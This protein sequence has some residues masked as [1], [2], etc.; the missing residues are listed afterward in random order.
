ML[1]KIED[2]DVGIALWEAGLLLNSEGAEWYEVALHHTAGR[3]VQ[4]IYRRW[5]ND[6]Y[7]E[8]EE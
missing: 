6:A 7:I 8:L 3:N 1:N 5:A 2:E 4:E